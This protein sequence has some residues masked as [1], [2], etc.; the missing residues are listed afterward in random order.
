MDLLL[1]CFT[2]RVIK[3]NVNNLNIYNTIEAKNF[4]LIGI[5]IKTKDLLTNWNRILLFT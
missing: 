5:K 4:C 3:R 1:P 2:K